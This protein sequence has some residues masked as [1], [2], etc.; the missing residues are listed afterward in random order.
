MHKPFRSTLSNKTIAEISAKMG[1]PGFEGRPGLQQYYENYILISLV[2]LLFFGML[3]LGSAPV[4]L[5]LA[6]FQGPNWTV[7]WLLFFGVGVVASICLMA[8]IAII[9]L[10]VQL[11]SPLE[12]QNRTQHLF[13]LI[14][15]I[16]FFILLTW[17]ALQ[18]PDSPR[19]PIDYIRVTATGLLGLA[20]YVNIVISELRKY[21]WRSRTAVVRFIGSL[22]VV[23]GI[24]IAFSGV[25]F[26]LSRIAW[27]SPIQLFGITVQNIGLILSIGFRLP[28]AQPQ[29]PS[30][31]R[32]RASPISIVL[33]TIV[34]IG[35]IIIGLAL[36]G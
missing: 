23:M 1:L 32:R 6:L 31:R 33:M 30:R 8:G 5:L 27:W 15:M 12:R 3:A 25:A 20:L 28:D 2:L 19:S 9:H 10:L 4:I 11:Q 21:G 36:I 34:F 35:A 7:E 24:V 22:L 17:L 13:V 26:E 16:V 14:G 29:P 18:R